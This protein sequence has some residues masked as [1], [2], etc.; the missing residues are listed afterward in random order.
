MYN[1]KIMTRLLLGCFLVGTHMLI[2]CNPVLFSAPARVCR[3][4]CSMAGDLFISSSRRALL[5]VACFLVDTVVIAHIRIAVLRVVSGQVIPLL[6]V[7]TTAYPCLCFPLPTVVLSLSLSW[8]TLV[9]FSSRGLGKEDLP[10]DV[11]EL[12]PSV[13]LLAVQTVPP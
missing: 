3:R 6:E 11:A 9:F 13:A 7:R 5:L 4:L 10:K 2:V 1:K 12:K 8:S